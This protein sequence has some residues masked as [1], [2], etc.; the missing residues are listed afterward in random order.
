M[1]PVTLSTER[2]LL[3]PLEPRD[4][5]AVL[6]A[7]QDPEIPRWIPVPDPYGR[8]HAEDFVLNAS[9]AGWREDTMYNFGVFTRQ[10]A[11][12][13]SMGLVRL[14][15]LR[16]AE[17]QAELGY[18]T[19]KE[20]RGKGYTAEAGRAV[21]DWAFTQ[22]GVERLEWC[23]QVGNEGSRAV[24]LRVGFVMEGIQRSRIV[25]RGTR[26]DAWVASVLPSDWGRQTT[27]PYLPAR[28]E[29]AD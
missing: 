3:R 27:T 2:L 16:T 17:H 28:A 10:G 15:Q 4:V 26:R 20:H 11:L 29:L 5:D 23:A 18:W 8:E 19:A 24:A 12:T 22:L 14:A 9:P 1:E 6:V 25:H 7:C 13:G 21:V